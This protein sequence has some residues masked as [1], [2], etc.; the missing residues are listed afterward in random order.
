M[1]SVEEQKQDYII[2][3]KAEMDMYLRSKTWVQKVESIERMNIADRTAKEAMQKA[4]RT[5][6]VATT[7]VTEIL[8]SPE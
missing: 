3:A 4:R 5:D 7:S 2:G 6:A 8:S 1:K